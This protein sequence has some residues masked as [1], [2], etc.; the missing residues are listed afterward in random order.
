MEDNDEKQMQILCLDP[1]PKQDSDGSQLGD[2]RM[3][4]PKLLHPMR[5]APREPPPLP[6]RDRS[7]DHGAIIGKLH[8]SP[9][10]AIF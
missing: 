2:K 1:G 8:H 9:T 4:T 5:P 10:D 3:A 6:L 7:V